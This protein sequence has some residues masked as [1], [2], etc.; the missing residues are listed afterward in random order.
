MVIRYGRLY[1][2]DTYYE[3]ERPPPPRIGIDEAA[4]PT[5]LILDA[6]PGILEIVE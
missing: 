2:P 4:R 5:M 6:R 3:T 1:G